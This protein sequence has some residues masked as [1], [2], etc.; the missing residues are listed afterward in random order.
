MTESFAIDQYYANNPEDLFTGQLGEL[1][2]EIDSKVVLEGG[3]SSVIIRTLYA[4]GSRQPIYSVQGTRC[5]Y[6]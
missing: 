6:R 5:H 3:L 4:D 2:V 1:S